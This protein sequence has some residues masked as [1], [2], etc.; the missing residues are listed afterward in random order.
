[1][2][3]EK[4]LNVE[5][6]TL[7]YGEED[8]VHNASLSLEKGEIG[9]LLGPSGCGKSTLLRAIA[10]FEPVKSGRICMRGQVLSDAHNILP[11]EQRNIGM[12]FQ[13]IALFP[14]LT[15]AENIVFGIKKW[16]KKDQ[17]LRVQELLSLIGLPD[18]AERYPHSLSGGQQQRVALARAMAPK[19]D[20]LLLDEPFSGLDANLRETL[21]PEIR[22]ILRKEQMSAILVTHDQMEAFAMADKIAVMQ[23]GRIQ[24]CGSAF[25]IYHEPK[26]R[27]V[28]DF[29]G[30]G[31]FL[32]ASI[33]DEYSVDSAL[34]CLVGDEPLGYAPGTSVELLIRPDDIQHSEQSS[35]TGRIVSKWF[36]GSHYLYHVKLANGEVLPCI[37][38][39][40][41]DHDVGEDLGISIELDHLVVLPIC[42]PETG[43]CDLQESEVVQT[44]AVAR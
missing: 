39:C 10:G 43:V 23:H 2:K 17:T 24:Q 37:T 28:A 8:V 40:H 21:V 22:D 25:N 15:I 11:T 7:A 44:Q 9:C 6:V 12:V 33:K 18:I 42:D 36:R 14:H 27:F 26:N 3:I 32:Q 5:S 30:L 20:L 19:P 16:S 13:D 31:E 38:A 34:G 41:H 29:I 35:L 4:H 1:M